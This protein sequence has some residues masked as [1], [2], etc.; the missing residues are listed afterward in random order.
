MM[1]NVF[2]AGAVILLMGGGCASGGKAAEVS[3][4]YTLPVD[5]TITVTSKAVDASTLVRADVLLA[6]AEECGS[7]RSPQYYVDLENLFVGETGMQYTFAVAGDYEMP[8]WTV[9]VLP[10]T[11]SYTDEG[12]FA[13]DFGICAAG[14]SMYPSTISSST[15][16]F[17]DS[18]GSGYSGGK[19]NGCDVIRAAIEPTLSIE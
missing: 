8:T 5:G 1:K 11:A 16:L 12:L 7:A 14:A 13:G 4:V 3:L 9:T 2:A 15:L 18:C 19:E 6:Q 10:N 17:I